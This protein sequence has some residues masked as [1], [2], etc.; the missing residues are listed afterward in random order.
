MGGSGKGGSASD[1]PDKLA[2]LAKQA[3]NEGKGVRKT[4]FDQLGDV[5]AGGNAASTL[6]MAQT[7]INNS[8][9]AE[10]NALTQIGNQAAMGKIAGTPFAENISSQARIA[11]NQN[12]ASIPSQVA[13]FFLG[14]FGPTAWGGQ[15]AGLQGMGTAAQIG[16]G[17]NENALGMFGK[18][19]SAAGSVLGKGGGAGGI[20]A[21]MGKG[22]MG[23]GEAAGLDAALAGAL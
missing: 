5:L 12:T 1:A 18:L 11:G 23:K 4:I 17:I 21:A 20:G 6:P 3:F 19:G 10:S 7:A 2:D 9:M 16:A 15:S 22:G 8:K 14:G 13:Q